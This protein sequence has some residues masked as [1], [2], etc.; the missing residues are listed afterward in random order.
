MKKLLFALPVALLALFLAGCGQTPDEKLQGKVPG[1]A[2]ALCLID[3]NAMIRTKSYNDN[4]KKILEELR[5]TPFSEEVFQC[6]ILLFGST[7][8]EWGGILIQSANRQVRKIY[9]YV[10]AECRKDKDMVRDFKEIRSDKEFRATAT[11]KGKKVM[12][13]RFDDDLMLIAFRKTDPAFFRSVKPNLLFRDIQ[14]KNT[15]LSAAVKVELPREGKS[16]QS[17]D[18]AMQMLPALQ[19]LTTISLNIPFAVED[20]VVDFRMTFKDEQAANEMLAAVN[21]GVGFAAQAGKE[22]ADF[23]KDVKRK[24][25]K[26][27][28]SI[29]FRVKAAEELGKK[30]QEAEKQKKQAL[31]KTANLKQIGLACIL[32]SSD[33]GETLPP[34]FT[35]LVQGKYLTDMKAYIAKA[36]RKSKVSANKTVGPEN[37]S[38]AYVGKGL[39]VSSSTKH[40]ARMPLA[41]EK[42]WLTDGKSDI[43]VLF[44]DGHVEVRKLSGKTCRAIAE[45]LLAKVPNISAKE[46][47]LVLAN[48]AEADKVR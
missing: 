41:F 15:I 17:A 33:H 32:Y 44:M 25:E 39:S 46:K 38:Y 2:N 30:V 34:D 28:V 8:E 42:P 21:M 6:R 35:A 43:G 9:D 31:A 1:S 23:A 36:D 40:P 11:V 48:A 3:G 14:L 16:R 24:T 18:M 29:V 37:T 22:F 26:N 10:I 7:Q 4:K 5:K 45:E 13:V 12:A 20:P 47:Q 19:K 27:A